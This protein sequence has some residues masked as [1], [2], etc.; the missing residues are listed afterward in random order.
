MRRR[1]K[2]NII[3]GAVLPLITLVVFVGGML[4]RIYVWN[5]LPSPKMTLFPAPK[6]G[7]DRFFELMKETFFFKSLF[8]GDKTLWALGWVF[9][10]MLA[11]I[12][13]GHFRVFSA[14]PDKILA[15]MGLTTEN[16]DTLSFVTGGGAGVII[17]ACLI[18]ILVRRLE[19]Q[20]VREIS[21]SGDYFAL[22]L[23]IAI[24]LTGDAMR[25]IS[26][27]ELKDTHEYFYGLVTFSSVNLPDN[28]WFITH[29]L[30][31]QLLLIYIPFSKILHFGGIFFTEALVHKH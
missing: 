3:I 21:T 29:F 12:F 22:I 23:L 25:F 18:A 11:L 19:V 4:Y 7:R 15:W 31:G 17:L 9:H 10:V 16:I 28:G 27:F 14:L 6:S 1:N 8:K 24:I 26:H 2:M 30:L 13:I 20:R 5:S